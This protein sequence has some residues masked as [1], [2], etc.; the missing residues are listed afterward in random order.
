TR[1]RIDMT[2]NQESQQYE[3]EDFNPTDGHRHECP[4]RMGGV[5]GS[6]CD[7]AVWLYE[8]LQKAQIIRQ[9]TDRIW[10]NAFTLVSPSEERI[11]IVGMEVIETLRN[12]KNPEKEFETFAP[13][14]KVEVVAS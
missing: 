13:M 11:R 6:N 10:L 14:W 8:M 4:K 7:C 12:S 1:T 5:V 9:N 2:N 3:L